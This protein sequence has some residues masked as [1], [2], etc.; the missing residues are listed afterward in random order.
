MTTSKIAVVTGATSGLGQAAALALA[1]SGWRVFIIG[2]EAA[3]GAEVVQQSGG[4]AEFLSADLFSLADIK[5]LALEIA[6]KTDTVHLLINN[7]GGTFGAKALTKD[8][9]ERTFALNVAAP[10]VLTEGL[11]PLLEKGQG[12]VL[13]VVTGVPNGAKAT[14]E[15][16]AGAE[17]SAG[18]QSYIRSK[19]ALL[20]LTREQNK[21]FAAK[22]VTAVCLHPGIIPGTRFGQDTPKVVRVIM[23]GIGRMIGLM[24][25]LEEAAD[26]YVKVGTQAVEGGGFY[27]QGVLAAPPKL[28]GDE[29]FAAQLWTRLESVTAAR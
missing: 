22:G 3:R 6:S 12:R 29:A 21:R 14:L 11:L 13:N 18:L 16:L 2:R 1:T 20:A 23:E 7:A 19:L 27:K 5:R 26:R 8:G 9:L 10:F 15:Q 28:A 17:A 4:R 25:T 24:S